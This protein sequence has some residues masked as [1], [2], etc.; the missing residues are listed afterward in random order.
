MPNYKRMYRQNHSYFL[1][2]VTYR[3][4]PILIENIELLRESFRYSK[5]KFDYKIEAIVVLPDHIH[6]IIKPKIRTEYPEII[7]SIKNYFSRHCP[8]QY[9]QHIEQSKSRRKEGYKPI[10]QKRFY[11][12]TIRNE[13]DFILTEAYIYHNPVKHGWVKNE[14][15]WQYSSRRFGNT[16][17]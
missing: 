17:H 9:Y 6:M 10:W 3:R 2:M 4:N 8:L 16:E 14:Q 11:E 5:S 13:K 1:T 7:R 15:D 12:H